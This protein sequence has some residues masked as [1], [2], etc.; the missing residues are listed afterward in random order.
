ML[1]TTFEKVCKRDSVHN[2]NRGTSEK[3][4][5]EIEQ[6]KTD[7]VIEHINLFPRVPYHFCRKNSARE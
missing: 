1:R 7:S 6:G 2:E 5:R 4:P 3:R